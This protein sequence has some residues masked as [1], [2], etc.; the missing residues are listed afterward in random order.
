LISE[1][2]SCITHNVSSIVGKRRGAQTYYYLVESARVDGKPRIVSQEYLGTAEEVMARLAGPDAGVPDRTQ[3]KRFGDV[4]ATWSMLQELGLAAIVDQVTGPRRSQAAASVGTYI[5]LSVLNRVVDPCSKAAFADWWAATCGSRLVKVP[6]AALDHRRFW[7][8]MDTLTETDLAEIES[9]LVRVMIE[10]FGL[11][12][13]A[14]VLDMTNFATFIDSTNAKAPIA[15]RGRAKQKRNDL[16][17]VGL[18]LVVTRD[19][20]IP[21]VSHA[22]PGNRPDVTQFTAM[23]DELVN[24]YGDLLGDPPSATIVFDA[25]QNSTTNFSH[26][27]GLGLHFVG[28]LPPGDH[29]ELLARPG[30]DRHVVDEQRFAGLTAFEGR[31]HALGADRRVILT[32]SPTLA[33]AQRIG[34]TQTLAKVTGQL[35]ELA[36]KLER[37]KTRRGRAAVQGEI[38][39]ICKPRWV[40]R[41]VVCELTGQDPATLRLSW[42]ID[43]AAQRD[44]EEEI[45]GKRILV[46]DHD[47]WPIPELV[48]AYRS[49]AE[50]E[51]G[52]RQMKDPRVVSFSPMHHW[53]GQKI[54]V[55]LLTC[56]L[57]L[58][59][60]HLMR[61]KA[62]HAGQRLSVRELL[63]QLEGIQETVLLHQ[64]ERGRPRA[65]RM[66][67][68]M[69]PQQHRL[70]EIF[71]L[72][73]YAPKR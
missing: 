60:A 65:R 45:F 10:R 61:R 53:T 64:A 54:R 48:A 47:D 30:A 13:T 59:A 55:H 19:G 3:H 29:P 25:G 26:L 1:P 17:L 42:R 72:E 46:T 56:V 52:F 63:G 50:V 33:Q 37:G 4:A 38:A 24:R 49:Q 14:L 39:R 23:L 16:R 57:A 22:Y 40:S 36:D 15:Q 66:I 34:F 58:I 43:T 68:D 18:G 7:G 71:N 20:G 44:L 70:Y 2:G 6:A 32:H 9:R 69:T 35:D 8:A 27:T 5:A 73:R 28:S 12:P 21:L 31:A 62:S 41:V 11:D 67:T 51:S